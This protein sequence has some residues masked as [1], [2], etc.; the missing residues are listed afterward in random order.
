MR[1]SDTESDA[2]TLSQT[3]TLVEEEIYYQDRGL[4]EAENTYETL[5]VASLN[6]DQ[7][8]RY[9][10]GAAQALIQSW[11]N[12]PSGRCVKQ[13]FLAEETW[14]QT[15]NFLIIFLLSIDNSLVR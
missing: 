7:T 13:F 11:P 8:H 15:K 9:G 10:N 14:I 3:V 5:T 1:A 6:S 2:G 4:R 12:L